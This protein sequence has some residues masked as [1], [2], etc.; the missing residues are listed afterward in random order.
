MNAPVPAQ[1]QHPTSSP[2]STAVSAPRR[3]YS[4]VYA[5]RVKQ[6]MV[7]R[8]EITKKKRTSMNVNMATISSKKKKMPDVFR[9]TSIQVVQGLGS[10]LGSGVGLGLEAF[11]PKTLLVILEPNAGYI[12]STSFFPYRILYVS[13][14]ALHRRCPASVRSPSRM[15]RMSVQ[16]LV[17]QE[18]I[19]IVPFWGSHSEPKGNSS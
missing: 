4:P 17:I 7:F 15:S 5:G 1:H 11:R 8:M 6:Y 3:Q 14:H 19:R 13:L 9:T 12:R 2:T 10:G 16:C 18:L